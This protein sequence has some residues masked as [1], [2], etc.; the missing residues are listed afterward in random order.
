MTKEALLNEMVV[1]ADYCGANG[2]EKEEVQIDVMIRKVAG[3]LADLVG[4]EFY[5][6]NVIKYELPFRA[7]GMI[8]H[9]AG[10][11]IEFFKGLKNTADRYSYIKT[12]W[13]K[14]SL[15]PSAWEGLG[16]AG[17]TIMKRLVG[18][19]KF[20]QMVVNAAEKAAQVA[21]SGAI[22]AGAKTP[23]MI[24]KM[25]A[26]AASGATFM[27]YFTPIG[28]AAISLLGAGESYFNTVSEG[29]E[30]GVG[31]SNNQLLTNKITRDWAA[32]TNESRY[33]TPFKDMAGWDED[34][35]RFRGVSDDALKKFRGGDKQAAMLE[36]QSLERDSIIKNKFK[37]K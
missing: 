20:E 27:S 32:K 3:S 14:G 9:G 15:M 1:V 25:A 17:K 23:D 8:S 5:Y 2:F 29:R 12:C 31:A 13:N 36:V 19:A 10:G 21:E 6:S 18:N 35:F 4:P 16:G 37:Q 33:I 34:T 26:T 30:K 11:W 24:A 22:K 7:A 28:M